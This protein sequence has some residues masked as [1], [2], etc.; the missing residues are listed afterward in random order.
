MIIKPATP[1]FLVTL[2]AAILLAVV[3]F[4]VPL[5]KSV[6]FLKV[7]LCLLSFYLAVSLEAKRQPSILTVN[8]GPLH[9][10]F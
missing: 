2:T 4:S 10:V 5:I 9:S 6:F 3:S 1:G 8:M 7:R